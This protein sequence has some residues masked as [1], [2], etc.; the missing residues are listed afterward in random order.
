MPDT[1][2]KS[3]FE[4]ATR[5]YD[6]RR[7]AEARS[8]FESVLQN[9]YNLAGCFY[10]LGLIAMSTSDDAL[11]KQHFSKSVIEDPI[12]AD[13]H[14]YLAELDLKAD[15]KDSAKEHYL[16]VLGFQPAHVGAKSGLSIIEKESQPPAQY[17]GDIYDLL[18]AGQDQFATAA[19]RLIDEIRIV[20]RPVRIS[21]YNGTRL[22]FKLP[23]IVLLVFAI[24]SGLIG[25]VRANNARRNWV[26]SGGGAR[27][28]DEKLS[29]ADVASRIAYQDHNL[30][31]ELSIANNLIDTSV[32]LFLVGGA[33][34]VFYQ[35]YMRKIKST[36]I[37]IDRGMITVESGYFIKRN[38]QIFEIYRVLDFIT[39]QGM[40][41][42]STGDGCLI[43]VFSEGRHG[44]R[45]HLK[46]L[47]SYE[48]LKTLSLKLRSLHLLLRSTSVNKG[49]MQ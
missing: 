10:Y 44:T 23:I 32:K 6:E 35:I 7:Y 38:Y 25:Y 4:Q 12:S 28:G 33:F 13:A 37:T 43:L 46:G 8:A 26:E 34:F 30:Q 20:K 1:V 39:H 11:A 31:G 36:L 17:M 9:G 3:L 21:A 18:R 47:A 16:Q 2:N 41:N 48:E 15:E 24:G 45:V 5:M 29:R 27:M 40:F 19:V 14:F 49:I 42:M 22:M